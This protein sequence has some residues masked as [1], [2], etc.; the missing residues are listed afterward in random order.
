VRYEKGGGRVAVL[1]AIR[2]WAE[3]DGGE[4]FY[5]GR[6][7]SKWVVTNAPNGV[8]QVAHLED[9]EVADWIDMAIPDSDDPTIT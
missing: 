4:A 8:L 9:E 6:A 2:P 1:L 3:G 5:S 7:E